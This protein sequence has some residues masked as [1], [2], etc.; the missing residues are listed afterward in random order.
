ML[1]R[2]SDLLVRLSDL[3]MMVLLV[4]V[5]GMYGFLDDGV[6]VM[7]YFAGCYLIN[8]FGATKGAIS[9]VLYG[10]SGCVVL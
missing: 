2:L 3:V 1:V 6:S 10:C 8:V 7:D 5:D 4:F 9:G